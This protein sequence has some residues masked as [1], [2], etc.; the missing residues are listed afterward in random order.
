MAARSSGPGRHRL[1]R[2]YPGAWR[3]RYG[4]ELA[5]LLEDRPPTARDRVD[6]VRGAIDA[7][8]H[9]IE[10]LRWPATAA[11]IAGVVWTA[12]AAYALGQP[13]PP[14]WPGYLIET[15]PLFAATVP[16][17]WLAALGASTRLGTADPRGL[18]AARVLLVL[19]SLAWELLL[20]RGI[21]TAWSGPELAIAASIL[22]AGMILLGLVLL[23]GGDW[24]VS[25]LLVMAGGCLLVPATWSGVAFGLVVTAIGVAQLRMPGP[26]TPP[27]MAGR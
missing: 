13:S 20:I 19:G 18:G 5:I 6:L 24:P 7:H 2:L 17:V 22:A 26:V 16:L 15:L 21:V 3:R 25:G 4:H 9:P 12:G 23:R 14:D 8:L 11:A 27:T 10:P 1:L